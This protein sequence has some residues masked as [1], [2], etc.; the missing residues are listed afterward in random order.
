MN[1]NVFVTYN[2]DMSEKN[3]YI[4]KPKNHSSINLEYYGDINNIIFSENSICILYINKKV[5]N[6]EIM[7]NS[8]IILICK[9]YSISENLSIKD[10]CNVFLS[11]TDKNLIPLNNI[12]IENNNKFR[13]YNKSKF[14]L[15]GRMSILG[16]NNRISLES[17]AINYVPSYLQC[18]GKLIKVESNNSYSM[19]GNSTL[20]VNFL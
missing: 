4:T 2:T 1:E 11:S 17:V 18:D 20:S 5:K 9:N 19:S 8:N 16:D 12:H 6:I 7:N 3:L 10:N 14:I 13:I 15:T